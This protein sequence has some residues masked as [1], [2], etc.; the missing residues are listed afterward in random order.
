VL[1]F[2]QPQQRRPQDGAAREVEGA[3]DLFVNQP[4][5]FR[6]ALHWR[7]VAQLRHFERQRDVLLHHL[8]RLPALGGED[9][10][11]HLVAAHDLIKRH[12]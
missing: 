2:T 3:L 10:P 6:L 8:P 5:C 12:L 1:L 11:Q 9:R 4:P 7:Q